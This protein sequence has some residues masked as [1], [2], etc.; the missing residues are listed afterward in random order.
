VT[1]SATKADSHCSRAC[2]EAVG[3][4]PGT[5]RELVEA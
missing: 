1:L 5:E 2:I 3:G 4:F